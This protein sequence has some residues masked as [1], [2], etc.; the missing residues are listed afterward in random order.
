[1]I[2]TGLLAFSASYLF[3]LLKSFQQ[4]NVAHGKY[5]WVLPISMSMAVCEVYVT[6]QAAVNGW[7][8]V[9]LPVGLGGGIGAMCGMALHGWLRKR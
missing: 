7:G 2:L 6:W 9:V 1:V 4:L 3:V 8:W 5:L